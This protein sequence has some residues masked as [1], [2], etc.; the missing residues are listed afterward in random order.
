[1]CMHAQSCLALSL[2]TV[3]RQAPLSKGFLHGKN[4]GVGGRFLLQG[5]FLTQGS[6]LCL[7]HWK[8]DFLPLNPLGSPTTVLVLIICCPLCVMLSA[9]MGGHETF[10]SPRACRLLEGTRLGA[11]ASNQ[12]ILG[13]SG[14][15]RL[16]PQAGWGGT[17]TGG[18]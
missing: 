11:V 18:K 12:R 8:A 7:L 1:M 13:S 5:I 17:C 10:I 14:E 15:G 4:T 9:K 2:Q 3:A 6:N 16:W